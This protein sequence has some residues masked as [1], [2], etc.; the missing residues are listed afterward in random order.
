MAK[1]IQISTIREMAYVQVIRLNAS[2]VANAVKK[3]IQLE[4]AMEHMDF[5]IKNT[6]GDELIVTTHNLLVEVM[7]FF[8]ALEDAFDEADKEDEE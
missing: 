4:K 6:G 2:F 1:K 5:L 3:Q 8:N 7:Q